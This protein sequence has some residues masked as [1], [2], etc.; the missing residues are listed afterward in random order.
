MKVSRFDGCAAAVAA[1]FLLA[2][3]WP[4]RAGSQE[5]KASPALTALVPQGE[6]WTQA[7]NA[8]SFFPE[9]LYEH[10]DGAAESYLSYDFRELL[11]VQ[12]KKEAAEATLTVEIYDMGGPVNSFGIF[13]AERYPENE[14]VPVGDLGYLEGE[15][16]NFVAGR[17][18]VKLLGFGLGEGTAS[19]LT[20]YGQKLAGAVTEK[21]GLPPLFRA[22]PREGRV[23]RSE[24][25]IKRNFLGYEFLHDG[26]VASYKVGGRDIECFVVPA[27]SDKEAESA[28]SRL[29][30]FFAKD[31]QVPE[32][33]ALGYY[34]KTP[35]S[36]HI[37]VGRIGNVLC[38]VMR[39]PEGL[40]Q[41]AE[42]YLKEL[43]DSLARTPAAKG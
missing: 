8:Q 21:G 25:Y 37:Y 24:K 3:P 6:D 41:A 20:A 34:V 23:V 12:L 36:Q 35:Y 17:Y 13:S 15:A 42:K 2:G 29:L 30:D 1:L 16:L 28:L 14:A 19:A 32:K 18:Y 22:F 31:K 38:G 40:E 5:P 27:G 43:T 11:V 33:I 7:E 9:S 4:L 10:I 39:V 26:Y